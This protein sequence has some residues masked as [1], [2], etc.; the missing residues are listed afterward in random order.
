MSQEDAA[1]E[2][3]RLLVGHKDQM[4]RLWRKSDVRL[5]VPI[6]EFDSGGGGQT[7]NSHK[8][9]DPRCSPNKFHFEQKK[10]NELEERKGQQHVGSAPAP[11]TATCSFVT[12]V[13]FYQMDGSI[14]TV[15]EKNWKLSFVSCE[16]RGRQQ[17]SA[18]V[19]SARTH[20]PWTGFLPKPC[21]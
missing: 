15:V 9:S 21:M 11:L 19:L 20:E 7:Q 10:K 17:R 16:R 1:F 13:F 8:F 2:R 12:A 14:S 5:Q 6:Q 18:S 4:S 3:R